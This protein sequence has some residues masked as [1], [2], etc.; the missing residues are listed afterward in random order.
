[1]MLTPEGRIIFLEINPAGQWMFIEEHTKQPITNLSRN[2]FA[3]LANN[4]ILVYRV[5]ALLVISVPI[6]FDTAKSNFIS[7]YPY[8]ESLIIRMNLFL[9][10]MLK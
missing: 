7:H 2:C 1:M 3:L 4:H 5:L 8:T 10:I 6:A 9:S